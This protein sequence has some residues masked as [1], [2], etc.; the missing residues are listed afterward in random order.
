MNFVVTSKYF[1]FI[2]LVLL[3][4][5][6]FNTKNY[7][8]TTTSLAIYSL[9]TVIHTYGKGLNFTNLLKLHTAVVFLVAP[10]IGYNYF[11]LFNPLSRNLIMFMPVDSYTYF[12][13]IIPAI[14]SY[15]ISLDIFLNSK[16]EFNI[17]NRIT[18]KSFYS[19]MQRKNGY[20]LIFVGFI[21]Y[22]IR[23]LLP[24][25]LAYIFN[26]LFLFLFPGILYL[27]FNKDKSKYDFMV[28]CLALFWL[29]LLAIKSVLFTIIAYMSIALSGI[30]LYKIK[31]K[32][33][34]KFL[35]VLASISLL[36][37]LQFTKMELRHFKEVSKSE[38]SVNKFI[39]TFIKNIALTF[40]SKNPNLLFP[41][42][43][44][45]NQGRLTAFVLD[46]IPRAQ[47]HDSGKRLF[48]TVASSFIPRF[49]WLDKPEAGGKFNMKYYANLKLDKAS[50][51][52]GPL[53]EAYG[54]FGKQGGLLYMFFFGAFISLSFALF[55]RLCA[56]KPLL[57]F[58][59]P[60]VFYQTVYSAE[61]DSMQ[62]F[63][64]IFK[65]SFLLFVLFSIFPDLLRTQKANSLLKT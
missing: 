41:I 32:L 11:N 17:L 64:S 31:L 65:T 35:F 28:I 34:T 20:I 16:N 50:M 46:H 24:Q 21:C 2:F 5:Y 30:I 37:A 57:L 25:S 39:G 38:I 45:V 19:S 62:V 3:N 54:A 9:V 6:Y 52:V 8:V 53:G 22:Y 10:T 26:I 33:T 56:T 27:A 42:Y 36:L 44:R 61:A 58:W 49:F 18:S 7:F 60:V 47:K 1:Q 15:F 43:I 40:S 23:L 48:Q 59:L 63:N 51:N 4:L 12:S 13:F 29:I 14:S 55:L